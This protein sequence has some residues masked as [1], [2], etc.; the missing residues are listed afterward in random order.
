MILDFFFLIK[1]IIII[2]IKMNR[3][4][5]AFLWISQKLVNLGFNA[6]IRKIHDNSTIPIINKKAINYVRQ[7]YNE[8]QA[9]IE[10]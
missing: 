1:L 6:I 3:L 7:G 5:A 10:A 8:N 9:I 2:I 4:Y